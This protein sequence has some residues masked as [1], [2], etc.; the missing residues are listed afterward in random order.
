M[1]TTK[2]ILA[3][4]T[5]LVLCLAPMTLMVWAADGGY[6]RYCEHYSVYTT[7]PNTVVGSKIYIR[8][9]NTC[10]ELP[11][12]TLLTKCQTSSCNHVFAEEITYKKYGHVD[13]YQHEANGRWTCRECGYQMP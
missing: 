9:A 3:L 10:F 5:A 8:T 12:L 4:L 6:C 11:T 7:Y 2:R 1:K 13:M